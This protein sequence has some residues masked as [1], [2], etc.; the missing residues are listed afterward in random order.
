MTSLPPSRINEIF[1]ERFGENFRDHQPLSQV[2]PTGLGGVADYFLVAQWANDLVDAAM[3]AIE[4][5][6]PYRVLGS[7][8]GVLVGESGFPGLIIQNQTSGCTRLGGSS[9]VVVESGTKLSFLVHSLASQGLG[10]LEFLSLIPG[11]VGGAVASTAWQNGQRISSFVREIRL[12]DS[13]RRKVATVPFSD[14][15]TPAGA[16]LFGDDLVFPPIL[17]SVTFQMAQLSQDEILRRLNVLGKGKRDWPATAVAM[18]FIDPISQIP[19]EKEVVRELGRIGIRYQAGQELLI[20]NPEKV[21]P[22]Q[23]RQAL[24][25]LQ[26]QAARFGVET[27]PRITYLGYYQDKD[28]ES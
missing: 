9:R 6:I 21:R 18:P 1:A 13:D 8:T 3:L 14:E 10:G 7:G 12:F 25:L 4:H 16:P 19:M 15:E 2:L 24:D 17:L 5:K 11:T 23:V 28:G 20:F 26:Q 27:T 22:T